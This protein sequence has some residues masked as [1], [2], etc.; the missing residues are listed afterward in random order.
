MTC[1]G[2]TWYA[3]LKTSVVSLVLRNNDDKSRHGASSYSYNHTVLMPVL[4]FSLITVLIAFAIALSFLQPQTMT[5][6]DVAQPWADGPCPMIPTPQFSTKK[7]TR[8][9][10]SISETHSLTIMIG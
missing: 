3:F 9:L 10:S 6:A 7:V 2:L 1:D 8:L 4:Q 5:G